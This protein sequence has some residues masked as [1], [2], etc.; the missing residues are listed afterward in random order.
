MWIAFIFVCVFCGLSR[1]PTTK[2]TTLW[3]RNRGYKKG[4]SWKYHT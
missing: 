1:K 4:Q 3:K 2:W